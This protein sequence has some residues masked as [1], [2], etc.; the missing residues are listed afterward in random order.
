MPTPLPFPCFQILPPEASEPDAHSA[1]GEMKIP[2]R[3][4]PPL[5]NRRG[6]G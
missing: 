5:E 4:G 3:N 2:A 1:G 6:P